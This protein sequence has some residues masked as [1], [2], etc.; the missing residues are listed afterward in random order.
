V[1]CSYLLVSVGNPYGMLT[2][3][4]VFL[5]VAVELFL[6][7]RGKDIWWLFG[8]GFSVLLMSIVIYLPFLLTSSVGFRADSAT[9][10]DEMLSPGLSDLLGMSMPTFNPFIRAFGLPYMTFPGMYLAWFILPLLPWLRWSSLGR[11]GWRVLSSVLVFGGVFLVFALGPTQL[12]MFRWPARLIPFVYLAILVIIAVV[13]SRGI[14]RNRFGLRVTLSGV[15]IAAGAWMAFSDV[16]GLWRWHGLASVGVIALGALFLWKGDT[17][18]RGFAILGGGMVLF[19]LPQLAVA[20]QNNNVA[21]YDLPRSRS[22]LV[23]RFGERYEGLTVQVADFMAMPGQL[24]PDEAWRDLLAGNMY[25]VAGVESTTAYS[26]IGFSKLDNALCL[27]YNG[28]TCAGAWDALWEETAGEDVLLADLLRAETVVVAND[29]A[30]DDDVP[31]GWTREDRTDVATIYT[32]DEP[33]EFPDG[34]VS[35]VGSDVTIASDVA[36]GTGETVAFSTGA[37]RRASTELRFRSRRTASDS[38]R[39]SFLP[40]P[41]ASSRSPSRPLACGRASLRSPSG[42]C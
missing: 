12:G 36:E 20:P 30:D 25:S 2:L 13:L 37:T 11:H 9:Y 8:I 26:G 29:F 33:L 39:S 6:A 18:A 16:P 40:I 19:L 17:G 31:D 15:A 10:N 5:A 35:D 14:N 7:K 41:R 27:H 3:A 34:R 24:H 21:V 23:E 42:S 32:R 1:A 4:V 22:E 28:S 38:S